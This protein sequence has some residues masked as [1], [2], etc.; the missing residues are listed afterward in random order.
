[1]SP[2][3]AGVLAALFAQTGSVLLEEGDDR[4]FRVVSEL[5]EW[6]SQRFPGVVRGGGVS[7][8]GSFPVLDHFL[9]EARDHWRHGDGVSAVKSGVWVEDEGPT[10]QEVPFEATARSVAG[11]RLLVLDRPV[12]RY[13]DEVR[14]AQRAR[15]SLLDNEALERAVAQRTRMIRAR[16]DEISVRLVS[17][18][19]F[20][21]SATGAHIRRI[22]QSSL[23]MG[24]VLGLPADVLDV[25]D[26]AASM[27]DVGKIGT[28]DSILLKPGPLD[29]DE[30]RIMQTHTTVGARI[31]RGSQ[32]PALQLARTIALWHHEKWDGS[33]YPDGL[34]GEAIPMECRIVSVVDYYDACANARPYRGALPVETVLEM[35]QAERGRH[36]DPEVLDVF[37]ELHPEIVRISRAIEAS[38]GSG[39]EE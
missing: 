11:R 5:P 28:P 8:A 33:G 1:M 15:E 14:F 4:D 30:R 32:V 19:E 2:E 10:D 24:R 25:L 34:E 18:A 17:A 35:M 3:D 39:A 7:L 13:A 9:V 27:H 22:G 37:L 26:L 29:P 16:E 38:V 20:R 21:D 36:F 12:M 31:L 6:F 23:L